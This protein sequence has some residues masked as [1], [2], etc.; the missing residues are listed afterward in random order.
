MRLSHADG[1]GR[2][3]RATDEQIGGR[4]MKDLNWLMNNYG[5]VSK[6]FW[7]S[8]VSILVLALFV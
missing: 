4:E 7:L 2:R 5:K 1:Y 8:F 6:S 3:Y